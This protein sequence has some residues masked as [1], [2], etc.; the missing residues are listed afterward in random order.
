MNLYMEI[1]TL[2]VTFAA[3]SS[4]IF[5]MN[6]N[7]GIQDDPYAFYLTTTLI[8]VVSCLIIAVCC[9][10]FKSITSVIKVGDIPLLRAVIR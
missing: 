10:K 6:L 7:S 3:C 9:L 1:L 2:G 4:G 5:G 8:S